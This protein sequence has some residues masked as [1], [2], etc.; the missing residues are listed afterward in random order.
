MAKKKIEYYDLAE[1]RASA[2]PVI[3]WRFCAYK[4][5][6]DYENGEYYFVKDFIDHT[7][8]KEFSGVHSA[9][10]KTYNPNYCSNYWRIER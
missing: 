2:I 7:E 8:M 3:V 10:D 9:R 1:K 4:T 6:K 5:E